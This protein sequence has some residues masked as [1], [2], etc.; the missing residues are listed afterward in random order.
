[1]S[2]LWPSAR[3]AIAPGHVAVAA[4]R[5][6]REATV[7]KPGW[8]EALKTLSELLAEERPGARARVVLSHHFA[9]VYLLPA[10]PVRL[11]S[12]E[13]GGWAREQM[14]VQ[15]GEAARD[16]QLAIHAEPPGDPFLVSTL[17]SEQLS[18]VRETLDA[19]GIKAVS[20]HPWLAVVC[21]QHRASLGRGTAW[22]A[23]AE[24][25]RLMLAR[26][27]GGRFQ[28][29]RSTQTSLDPARD[30]ADMMVRETLLHEDGKTGPV[31]LASMHVHAGWQ[32]LAGKIELR[33]L[34]PPDQGMGAM[35]GV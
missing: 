31:W 35:L 17:L 29:L 6:F 18:D 24:P 20:V 21:N 2:L 33:Q 34:C 25:G 12:E 28:T 22:L 11:S 5:R 14:V 32:T 13:L 23:L 8:N 3:V 9:P 16:W 26:L 10:T 7:A 30:L 1:M 4:G 19:A 15:Y 27:R